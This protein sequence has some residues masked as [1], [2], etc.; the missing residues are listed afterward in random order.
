[1][2]IAECR[3]KLESI[4][5]KNDIF[6][7]KFETSEIIKEVVG[8]G[9]II[10]PTDEATDE[11]FAQMLLIAEKR[12]NGIPL[13]YIFGE[14][15]FYGLPFKVGQGVLIP[16]PETELL[17]DIAVENITEHGELLDL[18]SG[19]GCIPIA[20]EKTSGCK[21]TAVELYDDAFYFLNENIRLNGAGVTAIKHDVLLPCE[22]LNGRKFDVITSNPPYLTEREM[23]SLQKEVTFEPETALY[24][25]TDGLHFYRKLFSIWKGNLAEDGLFAVEIGD[26]QEQDVAAIIKDEG[27]TPWFKRDLNGIVRVVYFYNN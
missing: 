5:D 2:V 11:Q 6:D 13:Q 18:C 8:R 16:R 1:M 21:A 4:L 15:E 24:G 10:F 12:A 23:D 7:V 27:L 20:A 14:W 17:V 26:G 3:R 22:A 25:G 9:G 19:T